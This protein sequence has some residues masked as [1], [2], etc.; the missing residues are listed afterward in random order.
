MINNLKIYINK[1]LV[2]K[3]ESIGPN[4]YDKKI[5]P[6][7]SNIKSIKRDKKLALVDEIEELGFIPSIDNKIDN[8]AA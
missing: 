3:K 2:L 1:Y 6:N 4:K 8:N 5:K 7:S